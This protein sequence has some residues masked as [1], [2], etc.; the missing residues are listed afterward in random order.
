MRIL[1]PLVLFL[2]VISCKKENSSENQKVSPQIDS[3]KIIDSIN[4]TRSKI[5]D[6]IRNKP[7]FSAL[8]GTHKL[9]HNMISGDGKV[10]F[11]KVTGNND[12]YFVEGEHSSGKNYIKIKG[13]ALRV[14]EK[15]FNFYGEITQ[16]IHDYNNGKPY[17]RKGSKTFQSKDGGKTWRLQDM[18]NDSG[19]ADYID[20]K[21]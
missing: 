16:S 3:T 8:S 10:T 17:T 2:A 12:E 18:V 21:L 4:E 15:Y 20:I 9:I 5:N 11:T 7:R 1:L 6:S 13:T 19:F 14:S